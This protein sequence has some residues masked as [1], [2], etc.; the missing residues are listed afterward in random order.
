MMYN[1]A[2]FLLVQLSFSFRLIFGRIFLAAISA[3]RIFFGGFSADKNSAANLAIG[4][5]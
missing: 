2:D 4:Y 5:G 3:S 1:I